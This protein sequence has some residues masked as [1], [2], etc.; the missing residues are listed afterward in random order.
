[1][2]RRPKEAVSIPMLIAC[3]DDLLTK[4]LKLSARARKLI[5]EKQYLSPARFFQLF[6]ARVED[7]EDEKSTGL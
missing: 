2:D 7:D 6:I 3:G 4:E 1:M 5:K